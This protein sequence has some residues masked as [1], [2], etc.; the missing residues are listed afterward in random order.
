MFTVVF[1]LLFVNVVTM[2][3]CCYYAQAFVSKSCIAVELRELP[4]SL[5]NNPVENGDARVEQSF[6]IDRS[7]PAKCG[8][9]L[10]SSII[11]IDGGYMVIDLPKKI[12][13]T[14][15][16]QCLLFAWGHLC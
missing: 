1:T 2:F 14:V 13:L 4:N 11:V 8:S 15:M 16:K 6:D 7:R 10:L 9:H 12:S 5:S 3:I